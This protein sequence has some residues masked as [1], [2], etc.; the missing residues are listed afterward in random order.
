MIL[1]DDYQRRLTVA[2]MNLVLEWSDVAP[3]LGEAGGREVGVQQLYQYLAEPDLFV[4]RDQSVDL[5]QAALQGAGGG[6]ARTPGLQVT[7]SWLSVEGGLGSN[8]EGQ[9][10]T[11]HPALSQYY[12]SLAA[13][14]LGDSEQLANLLFRD[15]SE[16]CKLGP[17]LP[18]LVTFLRS[19]M[20]RFSNKA[21]TSN[22]G[23]ARQLLLY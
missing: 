14:T 4:G 8:T 12:T 15:V 1:M 18:Y 3:V 6:P 23:N 22:D 7:A 11:L 2:D 16:N 13:T 17:L 9:T 5:V 20:K 19:G 21:A 10:T